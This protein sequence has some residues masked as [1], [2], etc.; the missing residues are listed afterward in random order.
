MIEG[1]I[2]DKSI[3]ITH[4]QESDSGTRS[5]ILVTGRLTMP[6]MRM[7]NLYEES[8]S[9]RVSGSTPCRQKPRYVRQKHSP[10]RRSA[11]RRF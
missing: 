6:R 2:K 7:G 1:I 11:A 3:T 8:P 4:H 10:H 5:Q 9:P